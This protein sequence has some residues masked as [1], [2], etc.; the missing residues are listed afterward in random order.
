MRHHSAEDADVGHGLRRVLPV[1]EEV[2]DEMRRRALLAAASVA[3]LAASLVGE[4]LELPTPTTT[5]PL[6]SRLGA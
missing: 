4:V 6:P 5:P 2:R 3:L 1:A